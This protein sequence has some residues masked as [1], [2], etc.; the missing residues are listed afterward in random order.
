MSNDI[1][2]LAYLSV[3]RGVG[4]AGIIVIMVFLAMAS[5]PAVALSCA[6]QIALLISAILLVRA[7][8][9]LARPYQ[10]TE[11]W[12]LLKPVER[13]QKPVAQQVIGT[14]LREAYWYFALQAAIFAAGALT[15]ALA[16][17]LLERLAW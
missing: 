3:G 8:R 17:G 12:V 1:E 7:N 2:R 11:L 6:G 9:A 10:S 16:L 14:V 15:V 5:E 13:P 4:F